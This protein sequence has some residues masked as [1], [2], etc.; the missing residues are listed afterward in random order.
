MTSE[1]VVVVGHSLGGAFALASR[2]DLLAGRVLEST[3][4]LVR[5]LPQ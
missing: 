5:L 3:A 2:S 4:G 1:P